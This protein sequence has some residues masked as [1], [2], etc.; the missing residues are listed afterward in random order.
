[1]E[2]FDK[3]SP[4]MVLIIILLLILLLGQLSA[5]IRNMKALKKDAEK[6]GLR[7]R[8]FSG[9]GETTWFLIDLDDVV[10]HIFVGDERRRY[11]LDGMYGDNP[12]LVVE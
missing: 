10:V 5:S 9:S 4:G 8:S 11:N 12:I 6:A 7:V 1:M 3:Y 2:L